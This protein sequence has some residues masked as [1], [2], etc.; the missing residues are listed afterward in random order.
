MR[1][2]STPAFTLCYIGEDEATATLL[3]NLG[4]EH[5][6][7]PRTLRFVT[8]IRRK[9]WQRNCVAIGL[10]CGF[11]EPL[12]STSIHLTQSGVSRLLHFLPTGTPSEADI[13]E[14]NQLM[15]R[16][17]E[18]IPDFIVLHYHATRRDDSPFWNYYRTMSIPES[19]RDKLELFHSRERLY[20][21]ADGLFA[22]GSRAKAYDRAAMIRS[23]MWSTSTASIV[24]LKEYDKRCATLWTLCRPTRNS[25]VI[26]VNPRL[27][28][29]NR[30]AHQRRLTGL[31]LFQPSGTAP[32]PT[33]GDDAVSGVECDTGIPR[34]WRT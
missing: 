8:G 32:P 30:M 14:Y 27:P 15:R 11:L 17:F 10:S 6:T 5:L 20:D 34:C 21:E 26:I 18:H 31:T 19:L 24:S 3:S 2:I 22:H 9:A 13:G 16:E 29:F 25:F 33:A 1:F 4:G 23:S 12:E 28:R 7:H